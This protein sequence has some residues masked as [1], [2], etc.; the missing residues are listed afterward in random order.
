VYLSFPLLPFLCFLLLPLLCFAFLS[1]LTRDATQS[2]VFVRQ[3]ACLS[4][5]NVEVSWSHTL[6]YFEDNFTVSYRWVFALCLPSITDLLQVDHSEILAGIGQ[7][8]RKSGFRRTKAL[9]SLKRG[10]IGPRLL[11]RSNKKSHTR[12]RLVQKS[13]N[14]LRW[15]LSEIQGH[16]YRKWRKN[17]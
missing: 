17:A 4:V 12:F 2:A 10:K 5:R 1:F 3:V 8:Y 16:W 13:I 9:I 7:G 14:D 6:E 11:L 15:P